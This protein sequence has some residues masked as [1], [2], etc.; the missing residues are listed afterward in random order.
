MGCGALGDEPPCG[1]LSKLGKK[2]IVSPL[3]S[4]ECV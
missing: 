4:G 3:H 1:R 2:G